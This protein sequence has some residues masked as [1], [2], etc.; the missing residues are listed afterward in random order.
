ML[1]DVELQTIDDRHET[2][3]TASENHTADANVPYADALSVA[4]SL[5]PDRPLFCFCAAAL[6]TTYQRFDAGFPGL[7]TY[8]V[9]ANPS[10]YIIDTLAGAGMNTFD[11]ASPEEMA[12][13]HSRAPDA[14][15]HYHNPV[16]SR[17]EIETAYFRHGVRHFAVDDIGELDKILAII[18]HTGDTEVAIRFRLP[19]SH[20]VHDFSS[21]FGADTATATSLLAEAKKYGFKLA[22]TFHPGSQCMSPRGYVEHIEAAADIAKN[23]GVT[24]ER[25]NVGGG[26]PVAYPGTGVPQLQT[27]FDD[28][29][30]S[31]KRA[32]PDRQPKLVSEPGRALVSTS[33][34]VLARV[35]HLKQATSELY[36]NDG[37][38]G[39][40]MELTQY[41][42]ALPVRTIRDGGPV[43]SGNSRAFV[44]YGPTCDP[45]DR[46]PD[47]VIL[48]ED[49][50]EGD[51]VEFGMVGAYGAATV[52]RFN[53]YGTVDMV[54]VETVV[55]V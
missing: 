20:A 8:A 36:L 28:I 29:A 6:A 7:V 16:K 45:V 49:I 53:G 52:T 54:P 41:S 18:P 22:L 14:V 23:A 44:I 12:M 27:F 50:R 21:K 19:N 31:T 5:Q 25:L 1:R 39:A 46:F 32:F 48:P 37:I 35:K 24:L 11:V 42:V 17:V 3:E 2:G 43:D 4:S 33:T 55:E 47:P 38:Y 10:P 13:V 26:F 30:E 40:F 34:S 9:K 15:L 51:W